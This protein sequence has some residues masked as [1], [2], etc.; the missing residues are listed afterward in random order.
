MIVV[1]EYSKNWNCSLANSPQDIKL[2]NDFVSGL[3]LSHFF[4][5]DR[6]FEILI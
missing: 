4:I 5:R 1:W 6:E 3:N 2:L